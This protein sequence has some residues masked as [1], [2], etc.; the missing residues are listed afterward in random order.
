VYQSTV[1]GCSNPIAGTTK[2]AI[3]RVQ[4]VSHYSELVS[5]VECK[6]THFGSAA[7]AIKFWQVLQ[8]QRSSH[9]KSQLTILSNQ[10]SP[11]ARDQKRP[12]T[13]ITH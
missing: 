13:L 1:P 12:C 3:L 11:F 2:F 7:T 4:E 9:L 6:S 5:D 8:V 10:P